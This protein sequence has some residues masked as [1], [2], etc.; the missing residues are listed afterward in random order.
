MKA[1]KSLGQ[2]WLR[3]QTKLEA[4]C[5]L[6]EVSQHDTV[7]EIGPG[8]GT[9]TE[10]LLLHTDAVTAVEYDA[11]LAERLKRRLPDVDVIHQDIL[12]FDFS[13][14]TQGY[15]VVANIPYY[16]TSHVV[17]RLLEAP[18][19]PAIIVLLV[20]KEVA[21][22]IAAAPGEMSVL[23]VLSQVYAEVQLGAEVPAEMFDPPP[24]V[25]SQMVVLKPK[26]TPPDVDMKRFIRIVKAGFGERRKKLSNSLSGGLHLPKPQVTATLAEAGF[27]ESVRAQELSMADWFTLYATFSDTMVTHTYN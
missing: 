21:Q 14:L 19:Q 11:E 7:L 3:D 5:R 27:A 8:L 20:Q 9:L 15:K 6:A 22:R 24:K 1:K 10:Q 16:L 23:G 12:Q 18:N 4:M 17:R 25:D 26:A 2:H 13:R